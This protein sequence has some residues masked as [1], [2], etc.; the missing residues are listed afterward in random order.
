MWF[1]A[2]VPLSSLIALCRVLRHNLSAGLTLRDVFRQQ[3]ERGPR[4]IRPLAARIRAVLDRGNSLESAL[5]REKASFP[6]LFLSMATLGEQTGQLPEIFAELE[7]YYSLQLKLQRQLRAQSVL[8]VMNYVLAVGVIALMILIL[9]VLGGP[10]AFG[11][12]GLKGA[13][14]ALLFVGINVAVV[15]LL[16]A[17]YLV[18]T[19]SL[20]QKPRVDTL[21][22]RVP[23]VGPALRALALGRFALA[24]RLTLETGMPITK[25]LRLSLQ[26]TGNAAYVAGTEAVVATLRGGDDLTLALS[27]GVLFPEDFRNIVAVAEESGRVPEVMQHQAEYY[28]EEAGRRLTVL[29]RLAGW[30]I[31]L[32]VAIF[33]VIAIFRIFI[34]A[35]LGQLNKI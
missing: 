17:L 28:Q 15:V 18:A 2:Q 31:W 19:R 3:A 33:M 11:V 27:D 5:E 26:A 32:V 8:P 20:H 14:G 23:V 9:G 4:S 30:A 12:F 21:L 7:K 1:S 6:P 24:L 35:Y 22:L 10:T 34:T 25:A 16:V 13:R 29:M